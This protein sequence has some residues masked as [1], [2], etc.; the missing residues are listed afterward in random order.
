M[1]SRFYLSSQVCSSHCNF[2]DGPWGICTSK[3]PIEHMPNMDTP[4]LGVSAGYRGASAETVEQSVTQILEQAVKALKVWKPFIPAVRLDGLNLRCN[5][6]KGSILI[7]P[8]Y[9]FKTPSTG[10]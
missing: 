3:I 7:K 8:S 6:S 2:N 5:L 1:L 10:Y 9:R 4:A